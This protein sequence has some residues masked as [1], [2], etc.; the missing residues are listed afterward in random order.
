MKTIIAGSREGITYKDIE[1]AVKNAGW[2]IT[3]VVSGCARGADKLGE[4]WA[5]MNLIPIV[6]FPA[7]WE[8]YGK[9]AGA[10]RNSRMAGYA[11]ALIAVW[12]GKSRG[13]QHMIKVA[14][15]RGL[16]VFVHCV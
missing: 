9:S 14:T 16:K 2:S 5:K 11:E 12:D 13:T 4:H 8:G 6:E 3:Q 15:A 7:D 1:E 10:I